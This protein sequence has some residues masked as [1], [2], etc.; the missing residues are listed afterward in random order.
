MKEVTAAL[1]ALAESSIPVDIQELL[2]RGDAMR[3]IPPGALDKAIAAAHK[4]REQDIK[5]GRPVQTS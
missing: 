5:L 4:Q 2:I 3:G 1:I